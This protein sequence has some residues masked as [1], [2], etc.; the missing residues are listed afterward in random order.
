MQQELLSIWQTGTWINL[1]TYCTYYKEKPL[2]YDIV[3]DKTTLEDDYPMAYMIYEADN[4]VNADTK[5]FYSTFD[6]SSVWNRENVKGLKIKILTGVGTQT[7][8]FDKSGS[9][10]VSP[11]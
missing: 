10:A 9:G 11:M 7:Y 6:I 2:K 1:Q 3:V 8:T 5:V 4:S